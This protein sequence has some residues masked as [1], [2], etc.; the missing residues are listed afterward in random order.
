M[1]VQIKY[2]IKQIRIEKHLSLRQLEELSGVSNSFISAIEN[3]K[4]H[5][6]TITL[7]QLAIALDVNPEELFTYCVL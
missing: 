5:P 6:T 3:N 1:E 2:R 7:C 4:K